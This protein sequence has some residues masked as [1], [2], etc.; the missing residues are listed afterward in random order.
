MRIA[1]ISD[2]HANLEALKAT[3]ID[4]KK[5]NVDKIICIGDIIGKGIHPTECIN[6][7]R[8]NCE[9]VIKGNCDKHFA[10]KYEDISNFPEI[11]LLRYKHN[12]K[13]IKD[14]DKEYLLSLPDC[15]EFYM[16]GSLIRLFHA[17]PEKN[18]VAVINEDSIETKYKMFLPTKKTCSNQIADV[19]I[20]GHIH[21]QYMDKIYNK[22]LINVGS[23]GN[24]LDLIRNK[25]KDSNILETRKAFYLII[26]GDYGSKEY[27]SDISFQFVKL[28][29]NIEKE[30][31]DEYKNIE[32][33]SYRL[34]IKEGLYRNMNKIY[35][36][37]RRLGINPDKF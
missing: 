21:H 33:E 7:I 22:T 32:Q 10:T 1:I 4:I 28:P 31:E 18:N 13:I 20:Y 27:N 37:F 17:T 16:S 9:V 24:S 34:E 12:Q 29:Y 36:N 11:E 15:Y 5:K 23:V 19:A 25:D 14:E 8:D 6:L 26:E 3:L 30:L 2:I 35:E